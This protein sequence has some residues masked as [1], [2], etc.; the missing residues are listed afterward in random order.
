[1]KQIFI[2]ITAFLF[3]AAHA[4][5]DGQEH[6]SKMK[7]D[8]KECH[9]CNNPTKANPCVK[10]CPELSSKLE[11]VK[12]SLKEAPDIL[13]ISVLSRKY[14]PSVF[15]HKSHA[16]MAEMAGGCISCHH[17]NPPG[18]IISCNE[19][20]NVERVDFS[21]VSLKAAY[22]QQCMGCHREWSHKTKCTVCHAKKGKQQAKGKA[23]I[24]GI[25]EPVKYVYE[26]EYEDGK[27]VTFTH[28]AHT[29]SYNLNCV[30]CHQNETCA[31]CHDVSKKAPKP[32]VE[33]HENCIK[34]HE[35]DIDENCDKCHKTK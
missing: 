27:I 5:T 19:C 13:N 12:H 8:C 16:E 3:T 32:E 26:T 24:P 15:K 33:T 30:K 23:K 17:I 29:E 35:K 9:S 4:Q 2:Y 1:M 6:H 31:R 14:E 22:H 20:H 25:S 18:K 34:C 21:K 10:C 28:K 7:L 11:T